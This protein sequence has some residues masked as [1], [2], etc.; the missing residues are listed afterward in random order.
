MFG[1]SVSANIIQVLA[2]LRILPSGRSR[3]LDVLGFLTWVL[4]LIGC[5]VVFLI[6]G[7][8]YAQLASI[9]SIPAIFQLLAATVI[10]LM[11][12]LLIVPLLAYFSHCNKNFV[13][14]VALPNPSRPMMFMVIVFLE[15]V[16]CAMLLI[17]EIAWG[18][19][20]LSLYF[21]T[22]I[23]TVLISLLIGT[24]LEQVLKNA[25]AT[26][27]NTAWNSATT[28]EDLYQNI[29]NLKNGLSPILFF[30]FSTSCI[31]I[32]NAVLSFGDC[33]H[34]CTFL[35]IS[36]MVTLIYITMIIEDT[37]SFFKQ[38]TFKLR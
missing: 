27:L 37:V 20:Y 10:P 24:S 11:N 8:P 36:S 5:T 22:A 29:T 19:A 2:L 32:I 28:L 9:K 18:W 14:D 25:V 30:I 6:N 26:D 13:Q 17:F 23:T 15:A 3:V 1:K 16:Y 34:V 12:V 35:G 21:I 7:F 4:L 38:L 31:I 33:I